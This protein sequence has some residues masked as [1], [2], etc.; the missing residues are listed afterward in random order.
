MAS[1]I[2]LISANRC[3]VPEQ[4]YPLGLTL[5]HGA[6]RRHGHTCGM[7]DVLSLTGTIEE[8]VSAF[9]PDFICVSLRNIDDVAVRKR[10]TYFPDFATLCRN[11]KSQTSCPVIIGGSGFSLFPQ[12]LLELAG[13]DFG[14]AG[15]GE[16]SLPALIT[17]LENRTSY[18]TIPGIVFRRGTSIITVEPAGILEDFEVEMEDRPQAIT[19]HYLSQTGVMNIQTQRGCAHGCCYCT[20]P[21]IEGKRHRHRPPESVAREFQQLKKLGAKYAFIVD[22]VFNSSPRHVRE[23]CEAIIRAGS[24]I[25]WGCFLRPQ[26][27]TP[28]LMSLMARAGLTHVEFGSDSFCDDVLR[29]Y[30]KHLTFEDILL[31]TELAKEQNIDCCHFLIAGG[32]GETEET[33]EQTYANS[34]RLDHPTIM[35]AIGMRIYPGTPLYLRAIKEEIIPADCDLLN[36]RYYIAPGL[37]SESIFQQL[38]RFASKSPNWVVGDPVPE[39]FK[40]VTRL[41]SRGVVG[42][43][44]SY[45]A[46]IQRL[47]PQGSTGTATP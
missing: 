44:W 35:A 18:D 40:L 15:E 32:P 20:Y 27:L 24:G 17:A 41:R 3:T 13:A 34:L 2:L 21:V 4:V 45:F 9:Q 14:I 5:L 1:R 11:L 23:T 31:S 6:L 7:L 25:S 28:E 42:P 10:E 26:G 16:A 36:P 43:L 29:H 33:L 37:E 39:Y 46:A 12:Q 22:S 30:N 47:W 8:A 19:S 38:R